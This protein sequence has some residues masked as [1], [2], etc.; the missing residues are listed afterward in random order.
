MRV[1]LLSCAYNERRFVEP[2]I[3]HH[4]PM[5]DEYLLL[6]STVP[7]QGEPEPLDGTAEIARQLG[8]SVI[9]YNW[10]T[11]HEQRN[12]GLDYFGDCDWVIVL[13]PDEFLTKADCGHLL[14][15]LRDCDGDAYVTGEQ[16]TYWKSGYVIRPREDYK[17]IIA[18]R[19][20]VCFTD[21]RV[22]SSPWGY[23][24]TLLHHFS[25]ARTDA[26]CLSKISHYAHAHE[27]DPDW[28]K[29]V[30]SSSRLENLHPLTPESLKEAVPAK[31]PE[32]LECLN[33]WPNQAQK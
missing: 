12:A 19:P 2:H 18:C 24:P 32:E 23:A 17:Q 31:L 3:K 1:G 16:E 7:W 11:E 28:Y 25:W 29:E 20:S 6:S 30:W 9:E 10:R 4:A 14:D 33:L 21:K 15:F 27:L 26:E 13:D 22:V 8:V 5:V